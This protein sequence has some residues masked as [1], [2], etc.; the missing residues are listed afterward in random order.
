[1]LLLTQ[2]E[3][4]HPRHAVRYKARFR[5]RL[6]IVEPKVEQKTKN[7]KEER[8]ARPR[9][10]TPETAKVLMTIENPAAKFRFETT[11]KGGLNVRLTEI[12]K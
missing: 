8:M 1:M 12:E 2:R 10:N 7:V 5:D 9:L 3:G 6:K 4:D 11:K